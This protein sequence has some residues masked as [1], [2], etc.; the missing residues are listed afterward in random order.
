MN[1]VTAI[2]IED[3]LASQ[4][5]L[6]QIL[7]ESCPMVKLEGIFSTKLDAISNIQ[8]IKPDIVF[9]DIE[10][11]DCTAFN[12]LESIDHSF[13]KIIFTTAHEEYALK[14][15]KYAALDYVLKPY[16]PSDIISAISRVKTQ[17]YPK[18]V[19]SQL[20]RLV[21]MQSIQQN[22]TKI[23]LK[24]SEGIYLVDVEEIT[25]I[26][27]D[28]S[29]SIINLAN[30]KTKVVSKNLKYFDELLKV[31]NFYRV[32]DSHLININSIEAFKKE[33]GG[34]LLMQNDRK[35]PVS[36]RRKTEF[37]ALIEK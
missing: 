31:Y 35:I 1:S 26:E 32:H 30:G 29:Y 14:A 28:G 21:T 19:L 3:E 6:S 12:I 9:L 27:A 33:D 20:N 13:F 11:E 37:L 7:I 2:I 23:S 8:S 10:L 24:T 34:F 16:A 22:S 18:E 25:N 4:N 17:D 36:R 5:L 15:F